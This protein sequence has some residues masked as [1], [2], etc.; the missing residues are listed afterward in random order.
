MQWSKKKHKRYAMKTEINLKNRTTLRGI[1]DREQHTLLTWQ[2]KY[3][4][5]AGAINVKVALK[6]FLW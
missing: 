1:M 2:N 6:M 3:K 5:R 4:G